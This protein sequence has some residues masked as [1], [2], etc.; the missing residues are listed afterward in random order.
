MRYS[1]IHHDIREEFELSLI[2]YAVCDSIHQLS[3]Q[4]PTTKPDS[5]IAEFL[6]IDRSSVSKIKKRIYE[7][8]LIAD[9]GDGIKTTQKWYEAVTE[10]SG[11]NRPNGDSVPKTG[12]P[13]HHS[14]YNKDKES[15]TS[16]FYTIS[17]ED[18][19]TGRVKRAGKRVDEPILEVFRVFT[20]KY[21]KNWEANTTQRNAAQ[22][23][24][25]EHGLE[26]VRSAVRFYFENKDTDFCPV[27]DTPYKLD[28]K[29]GDLFGFKEKNNL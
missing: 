12:I 3:H 17:P 13:S 21:P 25:D 23:L 19:D 4:Y 29:W 9:M 14:I 28:S 1:I 22:R 15:S 2:E 16:A 8:G 5:V 24:L 18:S 27:V 7:K 11:K 26:Q 20:P 6:G 10:K